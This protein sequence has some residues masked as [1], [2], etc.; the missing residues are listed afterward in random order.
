MAVDLGVGQEFAGHRI[1]AL[2]GRGGMGVVYLAEHLRL[3]RKV[4][5]KV[6]SPELAGEEAF[7]R[8]FIRESQLAAALDHPNIVP[9]FDAGESGERAYIS[10]RYVAG[11][12]LATF[13]EAEGPLGP[14]TAL[15]IAVQV[16][17][18]L[19]AAHAEGLVH[20]DV[21]PANIL[22]EPVH[23]GPFP[24]R[25]FLSDFGVT[26][27]LTAS[28]TTERGQFVGTVDYMAPEQ[29]T[30]GPIDGRTDE[31]SLGCV[32]FEC[33]TGTV[34]FPRDQQ[35]G[36]MYAHLQEPPPRVTDRREGLPAGLD[37]V[38][39]RSMAK[40]S[41]QRFDSCSE[42]VVGAAGAAGVRVSLPPGSARA[43]TPRSR[44]VVPG[45]GGRTTVPSHARIEPPRRHRGRRVA[46]AVTVGVALVAAAT[47][48]AIL[49]TR[50]PGP[51]ATTTPRATSTLGPALGS[52]TFPDRFTWERQADPS[53]AFG[54]PASQIMNRALVAGGRVIAV[55]STAGEDRQPDPAVWESLRG[56]PWERDQLV[57]GGAPGKQELIAIG[58][59]RGTYIAVGTDSATRGDQNVLVWTSDG[60]GIWHPDT[61]NPSAFDAPG[62]QAVRWITDEGDHLVAVGYDGPRGHHQA[63]VW[64][65]DGSTWSQVFRNDA[66]PEG[67]RASEM[68]SVT[69]FGGDLIAVGATSK[70]P[71]ADAAVWR[72]R[73]NRWAPVETP[74]LHVEGI[75]AMRAVVPIRTGLVAVGIEGERAEVD[76]AAWTSA[77]GVTWT[78][79]HSKALAAPDSQVIIGA[80][81]Y[82]GGVIAVGSHRQADDADAAIWSSADGNTWRLA[83]GG[84]LGGP[85]NQVIRAVASLHG[86]VLAVG[87]TL[88]GSDRDAQVW[89][90]K[91]VLPGQT[92]SAASGPSPAAS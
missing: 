81:P 48:T 6:L 3:R 50:R 31:Y 28:L 27:H 77:D 7:R 66:G 88:L 39:R 37:G 54:G 33:F 68:W 85:G 20:R 80:M 44:G 90:G 57:D 19:D 70:G 53:G 59:L 43:A 25:A 73:E 8:R 83:S 29:I 2:I 76:A 52:S 41:E 26:K 40:Q 75:Q 65:Y 89:T 21:K 11:P 71:D 72:R 74:S 60:D 10:M 64:E 92:P 49:T 91:P 17:A 1:D 67:P 47:T 62:D 78:R 58:L 35:I 32:V 9:V 30:G 79:R 87:K 45:M 51:Q 46:T 55:G 69:G 14:D 5:I 38:M 63:A 61:G 23:G 22:L 86:L 36:V 56:A 13:L 34:P 24:W 4:A 82:L 12:D 16:A 18:A 84:A 15:G 42:F